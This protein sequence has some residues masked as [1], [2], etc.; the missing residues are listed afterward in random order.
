MMPRELLAFLI[1]QTNKKNNLSHENTA[2]SGCS[3]FYHHILG[4]VLDERGFIFLIVY[5]DK[6]IKE[7]V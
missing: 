2:S 6:K 5:S 4:L 3:N 1:G 7:N